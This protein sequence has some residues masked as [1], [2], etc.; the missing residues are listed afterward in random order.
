MKYRISIFLTFFI[1]NYCFAQQEVPSNGYHIF[2]HANGIKSSEGQLINGQP[3]GWWKSYNK[4][5]VLISEGNRKNHLLDST[6]FFYDKEGNKTLEIN[7]KQGKKEGTRIQYFENEYIVEKW[8]QDTIVGEVKTYHID[9]WL[10]KR[11]PYREGKPHGLEKEFNQSGEIVAVAHYFRGILTKREYINRIDDLGQKQGNWKFFWENGQ[12]KL[13]GSFVNDKRHGFFKEYNENGN[14]I[15]VY[16]FEN[17]ELIEDAKETKQL[18]KRTAYF[19]NGKV[20]VTATYYNGVPDGI[21]R[22]YDTLGNIVNGYLFDNGILKF[23][24]ITDFSGKRE[25]LWKEYYET[26]EVRS[27]GYYKNGN[28]INEWKF[29]FPTQTIEIIGNY[30]Q[31]G[32]KE[33]EWKWYYPNREILMIENYSDGELDGPFVAFDEAGNIISK[34]AYV[35]GQEDGDWFYQRGTMIETGS[36]YEGKRVGNW[37]TWYEA[38]KLAVDAYYDQDL[39]N[40]KYTTYWENGNVKT[41]GKYVS[42]ERIGLWHKYLESGELL[43]SILYKNGYEIKWDNYPIEE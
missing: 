38:K 13:E 34:G 37:K 35:E 22:E 20:A 7:Y 31:K 36:F 18:E 33:G 8:R 43:L 28:P 21:R 10:K 32:E 11:T 40:G 24:G 6:W 5:G 29:F 14:F 25:G 42:G 30:N 39:Y 16:K 23:E 1:F 19:P 41:I 27:I 4:E 15:A 17:D 9:R 12:L 2:Y 3:E 26:G